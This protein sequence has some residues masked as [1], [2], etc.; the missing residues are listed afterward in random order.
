MRNAN[1]FHRGLQAATNLVAESTARSIIESGSKCHYFGSPAMT[2][3]DLLIQSL[4]QSPHLPQILATLQREW[5]DERLRRLKFYD[6]MTPEQKV[7]FI[8]GEVIMHS[9]A[10]NKHLDCTVNICHL[11]RTYV[12]TRRLGQIKQ[13]KC[14]CVFPRNDY[15]PDVVF[16]G[17]E[18][19]RNFTANTM[20]F[21][22][23]DLAVEVLSDSTVARDRG[24]KLQDYAANGVTEYWIVD[25]DAEIVEQYLLDGDQF[26][27]NMKSDSGH[28]KS[29][30]IAGL[31]FPITAIF[32]EQENLRVLTEYL[33]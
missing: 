21:P 16:F 12:S 20:K 9:P 31:E 14:L 8:D 2:A 17:L 15:E 26:R 29:K 7:E 4:R 3:I 5:D 24:V 28:L 23:P 18:K 30:A 6:E 27:L 1:S 22:V 33:R 10:R 32:D 13:E 25:A 19:S 11:L